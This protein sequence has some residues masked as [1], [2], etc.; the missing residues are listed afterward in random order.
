MWV[1][2]AEGQ[3]RI[4]VLTKLLPGLSPWPWL[5]P[6][7][8]RNNLLT[9]WLGHAL[10]GCRAWGFILGIQQLKHYQVSTEYMWT[11][12]LIWMYVAQCNTNLWLALGNVKKKRST[13]R[14]LAN[15]GTFHDNGKKVS[16]S[17][18]K[19][20]FSEP[21]SQEW[22][23]PI[24]SRF[25]TSRHGTLAE[26]RQPAQGLPAQ[27]AQ[28]GQSESKG[29][30]AWQRQGWAALGTAAATAPGGRSCFG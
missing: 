16:I 25:Y 28:V 13:G 21:P 17:K 18:Q 9:S 30:Q 20:Y 2:V 26:S 1:L 14:T 22:P 27:A 29:T 6:L 12:F 15:T 7:Q 5:K 10:R 11:A 3:T 4:L 8:C 19:N 23:D 24:G